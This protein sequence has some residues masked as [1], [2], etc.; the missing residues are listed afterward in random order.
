MRKG[1]A[2]S[3][4]MSVIA[5]LITL[6]AHAVGNGFYMG[7]MFGPATNSG[8]SAQ[9]QQNDPSF[10]T[11]INNACHIAANGRPNP[12]CGVTPKFIPATPKS[13]QYGSSI[14]MGNQFSRY[15]AIEG[16]FTYFTS[17]TYDTKG[18]EPCGGSDAR[19]RDIHVLGKGIFPIGDAFD[20][21][22]KAGM[23]VV[24]STTAGSFNPGFGTASNG[25]YVTCGKNTYNNKF[26]PMVAI[27]A[28]YAIN[29]SWVVDVSA[30]RTQVGGV[31]NSVSLIGVGLSYHFVNRYCG[32]FLCDD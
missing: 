28:S 22:A 29:P 7:F 31:L 14:Y 8:S 6:N 21:F 23:A 24:Y 2:V 30:S 18:K 20:V 4:L 27:G 9:L 19:V 5:T 11:T 13:S 32:Q 15:A 25:T 10:R 26:S 1:I 3:L 17:V 16:G 12:N